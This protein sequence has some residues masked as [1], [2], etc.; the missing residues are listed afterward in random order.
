[1]ENKPE[2]NKAVQPS[3][4]KKL[5]KV[6]I[7]QNRAIEG[8]GTAGDEVQMTEQAAKQY[9]LEGYVIILEEK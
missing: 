7:C 1:M 8:V 5:V 2:E 4:N 3:A 6:K 9:E